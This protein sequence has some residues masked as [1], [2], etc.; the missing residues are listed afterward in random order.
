MMGACTR[1]AVVL[2]VVL[3]A[4]RTLTTHPVAPPQCRSA[5]TVALKGGAPLTKVQA[6]ARHASPQTT[7]RYAHEQ[8]ELDDN[9]VDY[10]TW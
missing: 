5:V 10:V 8:D 6:A 3:K 7:M 2:V 9:A 4:E 1:T